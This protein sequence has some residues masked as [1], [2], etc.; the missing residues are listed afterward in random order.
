MTAASAKPALEPPYVVWLDDVET[1]VT[2]VGGKAASLMWLAR[3]GFRIPPG[4]V[5]TT[6]AYAAHVATI[7]GGAAT[8][9]DPARLADAPT[10]SALVETL[11][12]VPL[13]GD[14]AAAIQPA[15]DH[16]VATAPAGD[17]LKLAVRSSAIGEDGAH[18]SFAGLHDTELGLSIDDVG[19]AVLRCWASLWSDRAMAYRQRRG[20]PIDGAMG[21]VVQALVPAR[22]A[23]VVFTK[24]PVTGRTDQLVIT[25]VQGLGE[26]M[27]SGTVIPDTLVVDRATR[28]TLEYDPGDA[29]RADSG[30]PALSPEMLE[31]LVARSLDVERSIG[32]P[33]DIEAACADDGWYLLQARPITS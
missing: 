12:R 27:V 19:P 7:D 8:L 16:L 4:F 24:H 21:V 26:A 14:I 33:V 3:T 10:R 22:A 2:R 17:A 28:T 6:D 29:T 32:R 15:L 25:A 30:V 1:D 5:L 9:A 18:A 23:A 31:E 13:D 11:L 20:L